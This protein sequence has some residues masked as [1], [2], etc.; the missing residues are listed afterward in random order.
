VSSQA[1]LF[2]V[3]LSDRTARVWLVV[4]PIETGGCWV[5]NP[6][7]VNDDGTWPIVSRHG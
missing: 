1:A 6:I 3:G 5:Q 7:L 2:E 4:Q